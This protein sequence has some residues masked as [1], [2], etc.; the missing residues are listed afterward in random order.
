MDLRSKDA[1]ESSKQHDIDMSN[2][3]TL[4]KIRVWRQ[5]L[6]KAIMKGDLGYAMHCDE[7]IVKLKKEQDV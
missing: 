4:D 7:M 5:N 6:K 1:I 2:I 3:L